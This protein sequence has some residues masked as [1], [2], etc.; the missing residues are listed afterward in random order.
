MDQTEA[1]SRHRKVIP[2]WLGLYY[3]EP[4]EL[5]SG[6]GCN[7][8]DGDGNEYLDFF[9]GILTTMTG[10]A[11]P[12]VVEAIKEQASKMIHSSTLYLISPMIELAEE[13]SKLSG[14]EDAKVFFT[15]SGT[16]ANDTALLLASC[17]RSSNNVL[18]VRGS[19]HG[20]SLLSMAV[21]GNP[22]YSPS[23]F[24]PLNVG[25]I[26][27][28]SRLR[29]PLAGLSDQQYLDKGVEDLR[30]LIT[31]GIGSNIAALIAE[32]IQGVGGFNLP[33]DGYF[34]AIKEVLDDY[35]ILFISDE[36]QTGWGRT[37]EHFWG[38]QAHGIVPEMFTFAKGIG[39]GLA[40]AGVVGK[41]EIM[42]SLPGS[43]ISTFG[44]TPLA[45]AAGLANLKYLIDHDLQ[46]NSLSI[47]KL[48]ISRLRDELANSPIVA[49][50]RGKGL[51]LGLEIKDLL[52]ESPSSAGAQQVLEEAKSLG[53]LVGRGGV[54]GNVL[55]I[56]P[57]LSITPEEAE[58]GIDALVGA[59]K[60][61]TVT[62]ERK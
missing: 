57:P 51:M 48:M 35:G 54:N 22:G 61:A 52:D 19:Y 14:I 59:V 60:R 56:A 53:V 4:I 30:D 47:G 18:A 39:N 46:K 58:R 1:L 62:F 42:D 34:G 50:I 5:V 37:G 8:M 55:R 28:G 10:Y 33:P 25:Y 2:K 36:V 44:G 6:S 12:E 9:G 32:P 29:G 16:E 43:S 3:A 21:T 20:R 11:I 38:Y 7:V 49:D 27:G 23:S 45:A 24:Y 41:P 15:T 13:I 40:L 17:Y 31:N 26:L